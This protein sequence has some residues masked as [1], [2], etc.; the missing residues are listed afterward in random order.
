M[1][2]ASLDLFS[3]RLTVLYLLQMTC[4]TPYYTSPSCLQRLLLAVAVSHCFILVIPLAILVS[5]GQKF[6]KMSTADMLGS[7][8]NVV[9][10]RQDQFLVVCL[11]DCKPQA[12]LVPVDANFDQWCR[13]QFPFSLPI[14]GAWQ[15]GW[16]WVHFIP[17]LDGKIYSFHAFLAF[18]VAMCFLI[19]IFPYIF[20]SSR[21]EIK[22][23][24]YF[25]TVLKKCNPRLDWLY[26]DSIDPYCSKLTL[27][28][29]MFVN[30]KF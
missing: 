24:D 27:I 3:V 29:S 15:L 13:S 11:Q 10:E 1:Y 18:N 22:P 16:A 12:M 8:V 9:V 23:F 25:S 26:S 2:L 28:L 5:A 14:P 19:I 7:T 21:T 17:W 30:S 6:Y 4:G 20:S